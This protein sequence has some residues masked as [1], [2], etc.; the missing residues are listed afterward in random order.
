MRE[1][2]SGRASPCQG[3]CREFESRLPLQFKSH[4]CEIFL[5]LETR[6]ELSNDNTQSSRT[7]LW[8]LATKSRVFVQ[9]TLVLINSYKKNR[10]IQ[11]I[12]VLLF[13][14]FSLKY[15]VT[16]KYPSTRVV[17]INIPPKIS[18]IQCTPDMVLPINIA[19]ASMI[20]IVFSIILNV[21]LPMIFRF[22]NMADVLINNA[23]SVCEEGYDGSSFPSI[24]TGL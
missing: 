6:F 3:E 1:W 22:T 10:L 15:S 17:A 11:A 18:V 5:S 23:S 13:V 7:A 20:V 21:L 4:L 9:K 12:S 24:K 16:H 19:I 14:D 8:E 2:L